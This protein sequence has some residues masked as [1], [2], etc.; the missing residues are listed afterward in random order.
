LENPAYPSQE[1]LDSIHAKKGN[2]LID[3]QLLYQVYKG[4]VELFITEDR[5]L[6]KK[7]FQMTTV[8]DEKWVEDELTTPKK[9]VFSN[10]VHP[11]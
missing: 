2:D 10:G 9:R 4:Y 11:I 1:F 7:A 6:L 3:A 8:K 5:E